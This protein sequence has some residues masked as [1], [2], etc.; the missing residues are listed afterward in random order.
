MTQIPI[1]RARK[2]DSDEWMEGYY[3]PP[4]MYSTVDISKDNIG[5]FGTMVNMI[6]PKTIAIHFPNM[7]DKNGKKVF[8]SLSEDGIGSDLVV[9]DDVKYYMELI[10]SSVQ[11]CDVNEDEIGNSGTLEYGDYHR[12]SLEETPY[13][14]KTIGIHKG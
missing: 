7:I 8:A 14:I 5:T 12:C 3:N 11:L 10:G 2:I 1:Y 6:Y 13:D 4:F 9:I